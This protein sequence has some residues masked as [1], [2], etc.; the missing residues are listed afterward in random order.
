M[1][2]SRRRCP[3]GH[4]YGGAII[5]A[6]ADRIADRVASLVYIDAVIPK[7]G[8]A[9]MDQMPPTA[10]EAVLRSVAEHGGSVVPPFPAQMWVNPKDYAWVD[11]KCTPQP[12]A[13][14]LQPVRLSGA[15][16]TVGRRVFIYAA[17]GA[18][19]AHYNEFLNQ[20]GCTVRGIEMTGHD[21]MVDQPEAL[22]NALM[23]TAPPTL[24][25][26]RSSGGV[27]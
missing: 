16:L 27:S 4:S 6:V 12:L 5:T 23:E 17:G 14:L 3:G 1:G 7:D 24:G 21:I 22:A 25:E 13:S 20:P 11:A 19:D 15:H 9:V 18:E 2:G 8:E 26:P 10:K